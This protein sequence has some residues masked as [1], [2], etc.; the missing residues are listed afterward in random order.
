MMTSFHSKLLCVCLKFRLIK[1]A[2]DNGYF[3]ILG[4]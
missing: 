3:S 4:N 2:D 1:N